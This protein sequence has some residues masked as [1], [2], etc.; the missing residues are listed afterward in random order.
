MV[1]DLDKIVG[2]FP[3]QKVSLKHKTD[4]WAHSCIDSGINIIGLYDS[5][6]RSPKIRKL[7]NY[8]LYNGKFDKSDLEY[9]AQPLAE[10][11]YTFPADMQYRDIV[12][13]I[14][15]LLFGEEA[16]RG[17][18]YVV[19]A[20]NESAI[21]DKEEKMKEQII[22]YMQKM[23]VQEVT[24]EQQLSEEDK[25]P[26]QVK[27]YFTYS[28]QSMR[29][30]VATHILNYLK[31]KLNLAEVFQQGWEDVLLAGE[32]IYCVENISN[33]P[34]ARRVNPVEF[35]C[36]LPHNSYVVDE[37][38]IIVEETFKSV[39]K[40]IDDYYE[41][42]TPEEIDRLEQNFG[43]LGSPFGESSISMLPDK[44]YI[45][46]Q[47]TMYPSAF[48][49]FKDEN[50]NIRVCQVTWKSRK[51]LAR[52]FFIDESNQEQET[53]V[54][55]EI[56]VLDKQAGERWEIFW[57]NEYWRGT[58]IGGYGDKAIYVKVGPNPIRLGS[59][60][61]LSSCK[62]GYVGT[63][64]NANNAQSV[65]LMD[66]LVPWIYLYIVMWYRTEL[67][68]A[69]NQGK[70]ALIDLALIPDGWDIEKWMYYATAMK[71]GFVDSFNEGKK[72]QS[73][74]KLAGQS[75][76]NKYLDMETGNAIQGHVQLLEFIENKTKELSGVTDQRMGSIS[77][78][79]LVGNTERAVVQSSHITEKWFQIH[80]WTKQRVLSTLV[81]V[82]KETWGGENQSKKLQY[83]TDDLATVFF[84]IDGNEFP[85]DEY[86]V[87]VSDSTKDIQTLDALK[88]L[89]QAALQ[90]DKLQ[91]SDI[92]SIYQSDSISEVAN[93][94]IQGEQRR[95]QDLIAQQEQQNQAMQQIE[96][97]KVQAELAKEER[98]DSRTA[99]NNATK[100]EVAKIQASI[101]LTEL[102]LNQNGIPDEVDNEFNEKKLQ[103]EQSKFEEDK[104]VNKKAEEFK[105]QEIEIK[106]KVANKPRSSSK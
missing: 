36:V 13:P 4:E 52:L 76:Q 106:K 46:M 77:S 79:E 71:F 34:I 25:T 47:D 54:D 41:Y 100:I 29:E 57:V 84:T 30:V 64:Y 88:Q 45:E 51:R 78:S 39:S 70:I 31:R 83:I 10:A 99:Q 16:K 55:P 68:I 65:S 26:E 92:I 104:R 82:A 8:Q 3:R 63:V 98:E 87:F 73:T 21:S 49:D 17:L 69:A 5:S 66:R 89:A 50:G 90:N 11:G 74:G 59:M 20:V 27:K 24:G 38:E 9:T 53:I 75:T 22:Q 1:N 103:L 32:E 44:S 94:L 40:I 12:S 95:Q 37:A 7:R 67:L 2:S 102:D 91:F 62:S 28:Y 93:K 56:Y 48:N 42:L 97:M 72:G 81:E 43:G 18:N 60:D 19:R 96:Q 33:E 6:R 101:K 86:G 15:N 58:R 61:N 85:N 23:L 105:K 35:Y 80:N 14:F